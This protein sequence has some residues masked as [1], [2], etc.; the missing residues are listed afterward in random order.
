[1]SGGVET[2]LGCLT[3]DQVPDVNFRWSFALHTTKPLYR[4]IEQLPVALRTLVYI[5]FLPEGNAY[6]T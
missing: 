5:R 2:L 6:G 1:M 4:G 3:R